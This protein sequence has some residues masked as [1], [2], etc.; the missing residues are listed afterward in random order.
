[1]RPTESCD[2]FRLTSCRPSPLETSKGDKGDEG[3]EVSEG[4]EASDGEEN[5]RIIAGTGLGQQFFT[6]E[7]D[8]LTKR[9]KFF[10]V[11]R[12]SRWTSKTKPTELP[13]HNPMIVDM[14]SDCV[15]DDAVPERSRPKV[16]QKLQKKRDLGLQLTNEELKQEITGWREFHSARTNEL[17]DLYILA[18]HLLDPVTANMAIDELRILYMEYSVELSADVINHVVSSTTDNRNGLRLLF[19]DFFVYRGEGPELDFD[20]PKEFMILVCNRYRGVIRYDYIEVTNDP[21]ENLPVGMG[22]WDEWDY[23][24]NF[25]DAKEFLEG[26]I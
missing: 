14:Y 5:F 17:I 22:Y 19:A 15:F 18:D 20:F 1:M 4:D 16:L 2:H 8:T 23:Y 26:W 24:Q 12:S 21:I 3:G 6:V 11:A 7:H 9:S 25:E 13:E 10:R